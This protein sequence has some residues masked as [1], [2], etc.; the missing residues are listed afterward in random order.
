MT[1]E[2]LEEYLEEKGLKEKWK[3]NSGYWTK[4]FEQLE[5]AMNRKGIEYFH[6]LERIYGKAVTE[7]EKDILKWYNRF[8]EKEGISLAEAKRMLN[9]NELKEFRMS[10]KEYIEKG[11]S[12]DPKWVKELERAS[13]KVHVSRLEAL[14]VQ[15]QQHVEYLMG[16]EA[17]GIDRLM[18]GIYTDSYY[19]TAFELQK[20]FSIGWDLMKLDTNAIDKVM[21]KPWTADGM[22]FSERIWGKYRPELIKKLHDGLTLNI[23]RGESPDKLIDEITKAFNVKKSQVQNLVQTEKAFFMSISQRDMY[24]EMGVE[25]YEIVATLDSL[26]SEICREMDGKVFDTKDYMPGVTAHPFHPRCR[27]AT[28]PYF[29]DEF[30]VGNQRAAR[31]EDGQYYT[32]P[33]DMTYP[34]WYEKFVEGKDKTNLDKFVVSNAIASGIMEL[35]KDEEYSV[36]SYISSESYK[37][38]EALRNDYELDE[39][40]QNIVDSLDSALAKLPKHEGKLQTRSLYFYD[41]EMMKS[42][43]ESHVVGKTKIYKEFLSTTVGDIYNPDGQVQIFILNGKNGIDLISFNKDEMEVLYQR[44]SKFNVISVEESDGK[45]YIILEEV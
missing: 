30:T 45:T 10:L 41:D 35:T 18:R 11:K 40:L 33:S 20:G 17:D 31:D 42:F 28:A 19:H 37:I 1:L 24:R 36:R 32:V 27:S 43:I 16:N 23:I 7:T 8:A 25:R 13:T 15:M 14:K 38:N 6:D 5:D 22:N 34:E 12:M 9:T 4:R 39:Y 44:D 21:V 2:E 29:N 3:K 26:T